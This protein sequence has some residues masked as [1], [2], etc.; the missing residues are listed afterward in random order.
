MILSAMRRRT[1][2]KDTPAHK[3]ENGARRRSCGTALRRDIRGQERQVQGQA[4][5]VLGVDP[6]TVRKYITAREL[7]L[8]GCG[9]SRSSLSI[10]YGLWTSRL[11]N[12]ARRNPHVVRIAELG[13]P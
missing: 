5:E 11:R 12:L 3:R 7:R 2:L 8:K 1:G 9:T 6:K 13:R 10:G 4:A